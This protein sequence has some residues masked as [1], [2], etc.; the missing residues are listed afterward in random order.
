MMAMVGGKNKKRIRDATPVE[1][2]DVLLAMVLSPPR[3]GAEGV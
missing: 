1:F 2:R 3:P